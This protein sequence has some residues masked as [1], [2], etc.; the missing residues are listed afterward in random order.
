MSSTPATRAR[1]R[2]IMNWT[3]VVLWAALIFYFST[4]Q[5]SSSHTSQILEP[6]VRW[7]VPGISAERLDSIQFALRK[8]GHLSEYLVL[9]LLLLRAL[10]ENSGRIKTRFMA[11]ALGLVFLYAISDE[12]HQSFVPSRTPSLADVFIDLFGG[13]CGIFGML[14]H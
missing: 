6:W 9:S 4:E 14:V 3:A 13:I 7:F 11:W 8:L 2:S 5:F 12:F 10:D 1:R